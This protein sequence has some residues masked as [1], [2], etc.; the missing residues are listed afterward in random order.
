VTAPVGMP[1]ADLAELRCIPCER[2]WTL[3]EPF[4]RAGLVEVRDGVLVVADRLVA[5]AFSDWEG[6][7]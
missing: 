1:L 2:A 5:S 4:I 3:V 7:P 6:G